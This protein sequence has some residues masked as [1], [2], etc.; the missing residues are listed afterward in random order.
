MG[1]KTP[2][3]KTVSAFEQFVRRIAAVPKE[4]VDALSDKI[5]RKGDER[6]KDSKGTA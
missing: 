6:V 1:E 2:I 5:T 4:K 3:T